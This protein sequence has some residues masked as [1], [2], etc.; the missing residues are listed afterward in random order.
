MIFYGAKGSTS[1]APTG[2]VRGLLA[3]VYRSAVYARAYCV[4]VP[5]HARTRLHQNAD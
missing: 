3:G 4:S 2:R 5:E 1:S